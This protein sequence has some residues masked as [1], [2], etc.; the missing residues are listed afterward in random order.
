[1]NVNYILD[2]NNV[3][4]WV[5]IYIWK[6]LTKICFSLESENLQLKLTIKEQS[7]KIK[8]IQQNLLSSSS[9]SQL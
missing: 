9:V 4:G 5:C 3:C 8:E 1:M 6:Q 2:V 7:D